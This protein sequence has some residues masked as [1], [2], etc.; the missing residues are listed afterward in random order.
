MYSILNIIE[1]MQHRKSIVLLHFLVLFDVLSMSNPILMVSWTAIR[2]ECVQFACCSNAP[3][4]TV[5][6]QMPRA[7]PNA[8]HIA[9]SCAF[10]GGASAG[11]H[12]LIARAILARQSLLETHH[13]RTFRDRSSFSRRS[14]HLQ[15]HRSFLSFPN[16]I[17]FDNIVD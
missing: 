1:Q 9:L 6:N 3:A 15:K 10:A 2:S 8:I 16:H 5:A 17:L 12:S 11:R 14:K 13:K 7:A 4:L